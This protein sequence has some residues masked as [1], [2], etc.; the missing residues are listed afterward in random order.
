MFS[1]RLGLDRLYSHFHADEEAFFSRLFQQ[2]RRRV[3]LY[4]RFYRRFA[5]LKI[6]FHHSIEY[7]PVGSGAASGSRQFSFDNLDA[8][9]LQHHRT[10]LEVGLCPILT[11]PSV[12][13]DL[14]ADSSD[15]SYNKVAGAVRIRSPCVWM[16][17]LRTYA[18]VCY[19]CVVR[20]YVCAA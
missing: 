2:R 6:H 20:I 4:P 10:L 11:I 19:V 1:K 17:Y 14:H 3:L 7:S 18:C 15:E 12:P 16:L 9:V 5:T 13:L 8:P